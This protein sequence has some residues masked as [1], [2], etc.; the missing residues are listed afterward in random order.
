LIRRIWRAL[1]RRICAACSQVIS[2]LIALVITS[3]RVIARTSRRT[4]RSMFSIVRANPK[5][6]HFE[7]FMP[8]TFPMFMTPYLPICAG[9]C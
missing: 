6:G 1:T 9:R 2:P 8:R 3:W 5:N 4:R 7:M